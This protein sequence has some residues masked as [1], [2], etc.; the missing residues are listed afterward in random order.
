VTTD[1]AA[2]P[3]DTNITTSV[4]VLHCDTGNTSITTPAVE[5][6]SESVPNPNYLI[7]QTSQ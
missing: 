7:T 3:S 5:L 4:V 2:D 1:S 6:H